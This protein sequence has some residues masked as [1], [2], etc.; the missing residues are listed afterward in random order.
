MEGWWKGS[1]QYWLFA[2]NKCSHVLHRKSAV[3][4]STHC[5]RSLHH[6]WCRFAILPTV[7]IR[8]GSGLHVMHVPSSEVMEIAFDFVPSVSFVHIIS[9]EFDC[10]LHEIF[11][12]CTYHIEPM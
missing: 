2:L 11:R 10:W 6:P 1:K 3:M 8:N 12:P 7:I 5:C 4:H 9:T